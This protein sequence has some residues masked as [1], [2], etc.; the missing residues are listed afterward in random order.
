MKPTPPI[1]LHIDHLVLHGVSLGDRDRAG[2]AFTQELTRLLTEQGV[3]AALARGVTLPRLDGGTLTVSP[4]TSAEVVGVQA[5][6]STYAR[7]A[8]A[9]EGT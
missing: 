7:L 4:G 1:K 2:A 9:G 8:R 3:P 6:R 5:A